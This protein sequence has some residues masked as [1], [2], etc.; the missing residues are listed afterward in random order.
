[1]NARFNRHLRGFT[2][3]EM[4]VA[5]TIASIVA[6]FM[7]MLVAGPIE[8]F[9]ANSRRVRLTDTAD[10]V[11]QNMERD[12]RAALPDNVRAAAAGNF[13]ALEMLTVVNAGRYGSDLTLGLPDN[14]FTAPGNFRTFPAPGGTINYNGPPYLAIVA[15]GSPPNGAYGFGDVMTD[16]PVNI[17]IND[18]GQVTLSQPMIFAAAGSQRRRVYVVSGAV[19]YLCDTANG[20]VTR[21]SGY[22]IG[23]AQPVAPAAFVGGASALIASNVAACAFAIAPGSTDYGGRVSIGY[24]VTTP[25]GESLTLSHEARIENPS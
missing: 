3:L 14:A 2:L 8:A 9:F 12:V 1:M 13:V 23:A 18:T 16:D 5:I 22:A 17:A 19:S 7:T 25:E 21:Y 4:V 15:A 6:G 20:T 10:T 11:W 24:T